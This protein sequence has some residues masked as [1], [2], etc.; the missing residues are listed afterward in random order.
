MAPI[1]TG[2]DLNREEMNFEYPL[3]VKNEY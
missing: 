2:V 3:R 1:S